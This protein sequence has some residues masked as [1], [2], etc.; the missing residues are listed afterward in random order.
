ML[1][2]YT[3]QDGRAFTIP[4]MFAAVDGELVALAVDPERKRWW[5]A[6]RIVAPA[7]LLVTGEIVDARGRLLAG[8]DALEALRA[9]VRRFPRTERTLAVGAAAADD[10]AIVAFTPSARA[11]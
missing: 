4:V 6:F 3:A 8:T 2:T 7:R 10:V 9:Y 1:L 5:R 11:R